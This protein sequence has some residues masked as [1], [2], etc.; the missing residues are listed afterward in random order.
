MFSRAERRRP[1]VKQEDLQGN[2]LCGYGNKYR[3]G[4]YSFVHVHQ[5]AAA[6]AWLG[7]LLDDVTNAVHWEPGEEPEATLNLALTFEG[8][9]AVGV[10]GDRRESF[11]EDFREG[12]EARA[13][14]LGDTRQD[15]PEN[16][17]AGLRPGEPHVLL[18]ATARSADVLTRRRRSLQE[19][20]ARS[21]GGLEI[22]HEV[23]AALLDSDGKDQFGREHFGF[24]DGLAQPS[25]VGDGVGPYERPGKGVPAQD[26]GWR[27]IEAGEFVLGYRDEDGIRP[28]APEEPFDRDCSFMVVRKLHQ[29]VAAFAACLRLQARDGRDEELV[30]AKIFGRWRDGTPL[31]NSPD[32]RELAFLDKRERAQTINDFGYGDD[33]DGFR[34]PLGAHIRRANPRDTFGFDHLRTLRH[35]IIRRGMPYGPPPVDPLFPDSVDRGLMFVC[36]QASIER[37]F[38]VVQGWLND[39][40]AFGLGDEKDFLVAGEEPGGYM[41][42]QG[43]PTNYLRRGAQLVTLKGGGYFFTPSIP[44]LREIAAGRA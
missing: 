9:G 18:T 15:D 28:R 1:R 11:P 4:L 6:R 8:L 23:P 34:C 19:A 2:V 30:A 41:T 43:E 24:A 37:Q 16:W 25:I 7:E 5:P 22:V 20:V 14:L 31:V 10:S 32:A 3:Y 29:D 26:G 35:R 39:G 21:Q 42:I 38:E 12:M 27:P 44:A 36:Y 33:P 17:D 40:D 13:E